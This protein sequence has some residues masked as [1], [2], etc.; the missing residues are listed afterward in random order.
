MR[1]NSLCKPIWTW[2]KYRQASVHIGIWKEQLP[3]TK[4]WSVSL[5]GPESA[6]AENLHYMLPTTIIIGSLS[7][8]L[9]NPETLCYNEKNVCQYNLLRLA[10][11][12]DCLR[13]QQLLMQQKHQ[14]APRLLQLRQQE[15]MVKSSRLKIWQFCKKMS[16]TSSIQM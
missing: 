16:K 7:M 12:A 13:E 1:V 4:V 2:T 3:L 14:L 9:Q 15:E 11:G 10:V 5:S 6:D 8:V